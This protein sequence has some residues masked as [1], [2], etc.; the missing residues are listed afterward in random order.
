M[1]G[2]MAAIKIVQQIATLKPTLN[3]QLLFDT[4]ATHIYPKFLKG[5]G[6]GERKTF[7]KKFSFPGN[8]IH[9]FPNTIFANDVNLLD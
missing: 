5:K 2:C 9:N 3:S 7:F 1:I 4:H 8:T 6:Y